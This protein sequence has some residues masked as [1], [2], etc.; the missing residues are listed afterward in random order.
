MS[1]E[2]ISAVF[3]R[4]PRGGGEMLLALAL[5]DHARSDGTHI[6]PKIKDL[7]EKTRQSD[8]SVQYQLRNME[9]TGWLQKVSSGNGGRSTSTSYRISPEWLAGAELTEL[10]PTGDAT[11]KGANGDTKGCNLEQKRVQPIAPAYNRHKPSVNRQ[12]TAKAR[13]RTTAGFDPLSIELP[14]WLE[15]ETWA[16]WVKYRAAAK[17]PITEDAARLQLGKLT[18][19]RGEG[20]DARLVIEAA[21]ENS[22]QGLYPAKDGSTLAKPKSSGMRWWAQAG[23]DTEGD[24]LNAGCHGANYRQF[25]GGCRQ[26]VATT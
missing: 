22:W 6:F 15:A 4:Y 13:A 17:K 21:I 7:A 12:I 26:E 14:D 18:K 20:H 5:A 1:V 10:Q 11:E 24:A 3:K 25:H 8:R 9:S 23:F 2:V 19:F 16:M